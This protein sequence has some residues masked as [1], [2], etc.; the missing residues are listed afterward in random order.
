VRTIKSNTSRWLFD[1]FPE[2]AREMRGRSLWSR[3]YY[4][5][6]VG[7]VT[8]EIVLSYVA[9][10]RQ[11]H[12]LHR[13]DSRELACFRHP[14]LGPYLDLRSFS[15]CVA[16]YNC[17]LVCC[18]RR[19]APLFQ[20]SVARELL[21]YIHRV[22]Q[23]K[24]IELLS[25]AILEDHV[26]LFAALQPSQSPQ[27]FALAV[28]NNT[29]YWMTQRDP[30]SLKLWDAPGLWTPSAFVRVAGAVTTN[31]VRAHLRDQSFDDDDSTSR[32]AAGGSCGC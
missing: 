11:H 7:E 28:M 27:F 5:R 12:E 6:G 19:H 1:A 15:H 14:N 25:G 32:L 17:H 24:H 31:T 22:A 20:E 23:Q 4:L 21:P 16:E 2:L 26:H 8:N 18:P 3:A 13:G 30:G 29:S 9:R 10:Q